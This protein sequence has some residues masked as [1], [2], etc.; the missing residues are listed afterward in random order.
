MANKP[1]KVDACTQ[2]D[3]EMEEMVRFNACRKADKAFGFKV[4]GIICAIGVFIGSFS[5]S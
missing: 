4:A 5:M 1:E 3:M 2:T